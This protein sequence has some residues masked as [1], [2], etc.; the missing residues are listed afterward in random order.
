M[1][2]GKFN[3]ITDQGIKETSGLLSEYFAIRKE[4]K[5][6][7]VTHLS[8]GYKV[9]RFDKQ[10]DARKFITEIEKLEGIENLSTENVLD[11]KEKI[12][13]IAKKSLTD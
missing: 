7:S 3:I 13:K 12:L 4:D 8:T 2:K 1:K 6:Y 10:K 5:T 11:W 9:S